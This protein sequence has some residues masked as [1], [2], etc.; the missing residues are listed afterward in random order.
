MAGP[1]CGMLTTAIGGLA[2]MVQDQIVLLE[3]TTHALRGH[4]LM[5]T[6]RERQETLP[7]RRSC[8]W[9]RVSKDV[10]RID[11]A[12][13]VK[14]RVKHDSLGMVVKQLR[15]PDHADDP[16]PLL[17]TD[18]V[19]PSLAQRL[20][21]H[22]Q[23]FAD[24]AGNVYLEGHGLFIYVSGRK[25]DEKKL[26]LP[27][28]KSY[29]LTRLKVL[30]ALICDP[31]L[32]AAPLRKIA[33]AADV[34]VGSLSAVLAD[35][36][37]Q[38]YLSSRD[39]RRQLNGS[40]RLLDDWAHGYALSLRG[41]TLAERYLAPSFAAWQEWPIGRLRWGGEA[42]AVCLGCHA[43]PGLLTLYGEKLPPRLLAGQRLS[44]AGPVDYEQL[45]ELR[46]PFWGKSLSVDGP[47]DT[48]AP[49]LI[50]ADL[51]ATG[52]PRCLEAAQMIYR[53]RLERFFPGA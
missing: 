50:Y 47:L 19:S 43:Q 6:V 48:V 15:Y 20:R 53:T 46:Q 51:L 3:R 29:T 1:Y 42:A 16:L 25:P 45:L 28:G 18:H 49:A 11:Y 9:L 30:F 37:E 2:M 33:A 52:N 5:V 27:T 38:G 35:F 7:Q 4:G 34:P 17:I 14:R 40:L 24:T 39:K 31:D 32:A 23:H 36:K 21:E 10:C 12:A 22:H 44:L 13:E 8:T 41:K 26:A